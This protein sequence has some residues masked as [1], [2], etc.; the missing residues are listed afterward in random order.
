MDA[1]V[2]QLMHTTPHIGPWGAA[3][4]GKMKVENIALTPTLK[5]W[6]FALLKDKVPEPGILA[7]NVSAFVSVDYTIRGGQIIYQ[8]AATRS[9][10]KR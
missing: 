7:T 5:L 6:R 2:D 3:L 4:V 10:V 9:G 1:G 8:A